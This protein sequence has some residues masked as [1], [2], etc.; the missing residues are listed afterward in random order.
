MLERLHEL[1]KQRADFA[2]ETTLAGRTLA[3]WLDN[4]RQSGHRVH[5]VYFWLDNADL[6][7]ARV[8]ERVRLGGHNIP[9]KTIRQRYRRSIRNFFQLYQAVVSSW[10]VYDNSSPG[11]P[12][13]VALVDENGEQTIHIE[14]IWQQIQKELEL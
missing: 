13:L 3:G 1:A 2:F 8:T 11:V 4:L 9:E 14:R 5:L 6:A 12:Q 7:V 10:R